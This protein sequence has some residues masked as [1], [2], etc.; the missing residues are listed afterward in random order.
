[1]E[2]A[3]FISAIAS[4]IAIPISIWSIISSK[5]NSNR[6]EEINKIIQIQQRNFGNTITVG[7]A[8]NNGV[9]GVNINQQ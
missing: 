8:N 4:V 5:K 9:S 1:M 2:T 6:I 7:N 3:T